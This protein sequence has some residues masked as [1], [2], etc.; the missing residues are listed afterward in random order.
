MDNSYECRGQ[1]GAESPYE[2][3]PPAPCPAA[4]AAVAL[5]HHTVV[6]SP[7]FAMIFV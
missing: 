3:S 5:T 1:P 4:I 6:R 2:E 7:T